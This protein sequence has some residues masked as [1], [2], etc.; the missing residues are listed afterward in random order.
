MESA[1]ITLR[2]LNGERAEMEDLQ[3]VIEAAPE[4]A[5]R[6]TGVPP[7]PADALSTFSIL[8]EGKSYEDKFVFGVY[9]DE[10]MVGFMDVVRGHPD[11]STA[12]LSLLLIAE[13]FRRRGIGRAAYHEVESVIVGWGTCDRIR[14]SVLRVNEQVIPFARKMGFQPTGET[15][16]YRYGSVVSEHMLFEKSFGHADA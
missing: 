12:Y 13:P 14:T 5:E 9:V 16:P 4:Y 11:P 3:R 2:L 15:R 10:R 6:V 8:P 7:G 1:R